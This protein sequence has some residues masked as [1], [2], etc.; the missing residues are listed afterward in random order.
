MYKVLIVDD[1]SIIRKGLK[2]IIDWK[3]LGCEVCGE[4]SDGIEGI[5]MIREVRPHIL[6][7]DIN[8]PEIDGLSMIKET[9]QLLPES[10]IIILTGYRDFEYIQEAIRLGAFDY[11]L[12][13]SKIEDLTAII[14]KAIA[15]LQ[16]GCMLEEE[17]SRLKK[18]F[19]SKIPVLRQKLLYD[20]MFRINTKKEEILEELSLYGLAVDDFTIMAVETDDDGQENMKSQYER[21]LYQFG[22][23]NTFEEMLSARF[24]V[25]EVPINSKTT[26][27]IIQAKE[28]G[29][30][31]M[32][33]SLYRD[34]VSLQ[35]LVRNCF[36]FTVTIS[37]ST[38]GKGAFELA[39]KAKESLEALDYKFY[40]GKNTIILYDDLKSFYKST[41]FSMLEHYEKVLVQKVRSGNAES[42]ASALKD[43]LKCVNE[44]KLDRESIKKFYWNAINMIFTLPTTMKLDD[45][46]PS[47][48][49]ITEIFGILDQCESLMEL[50]GI[51]EDLAINIA[52]RINSFNRKTINSTLQKAMDYISLN[53]KES[54]TL[55][56]VAEHT[57]VSIYYLSRMFTKELGKNYVDYLNEVRIEKAKEYLRDSC[58][59]TYEIAELVGIKDAHYFSKLFKKYTGVTPSEY[60]SGC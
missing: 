50:N 46:S 2:N 26:V 40:M 35:E 51:L 41:D 1:E 13:P 9:K 55:N 16:H 59:K 29:V 11:I 56:E 6:I 47:S 28:T 43:I 23:I 7:T 45:E 5:R 20:I 31:D 57:Y 19:E 17:L 24:K 53:Y 44:C 52:N 54:I 36:S 12:K 3:S 48:R 15:E 34:A 4:A 10:K 21:H 27:F 39:D 37:I 18:H 49:R 25:A 8:M 22:I 30:E 33:G 38:R 42:V 32:S 14:N 58:Y 60:K